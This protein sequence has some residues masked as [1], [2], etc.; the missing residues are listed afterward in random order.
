MDRVPVG[1]GSLLSSA[2]GGLISID[3]CGYFDY[4]DLETG[5]GDGEGPGLCLGVAVG[6]E[7]PL[8]MGGRG[9]QFDLVEA[10]LQGLDVSGAAAWSARG[11]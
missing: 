4:G 9:E 11:V 2:G 6:G 5:D 10:R 3:G 7:G 1:N 8:G